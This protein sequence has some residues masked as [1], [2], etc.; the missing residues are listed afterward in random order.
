MALGDGWILTVTWP[1]FGGSYRGAMHHKLLGVCTVG[2][3]GLQSLKIRPLES[4]RGVRHQARVGILPGE[5][6]PGGLGTLRLQ[7]RITGGTSQLYL[8]GLLSFYSWTVGGHIAGG[9]GMVADFSRRK[10]LPHRELIH[11]L[12]E[13]EK[14]TTPSSRPLPAICTV[15]TFHMQICD[16]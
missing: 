9:Q 14:D 2:G 6:C 1:P 10:D 15:P 3:F 8:E 12:Y 7:P 13:L 11:Y 4:K 16:S 5:E